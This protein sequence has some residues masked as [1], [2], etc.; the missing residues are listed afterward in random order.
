MRLN[1]LF[2]QVVAIASLLAIAHCNPQFGGYGGY[3][4]LGGG[5]GGGYGGGLGGGSGGG[6]KQISIGN[7][8]GGYGGYEGHKEVFVDYRVS[9]VSFFQIFYYVRNF[10]SSYWNSLK[11]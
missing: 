9:V 11:F 10:M 1:R 5:S 6:Y 8:G 2:F 4:G 3:G 7:I